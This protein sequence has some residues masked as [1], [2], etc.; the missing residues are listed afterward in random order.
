MLASKLPRCCKS[1]IGESNKCMVFLH[2]LVGWD[3]DLRTAATRTA[4]E[5]EIGPWRVWRWWDPPWDNTSIVS[6]CNLVEGG[7]RE[8]WSPIK[9]MITTPLRTWLTPKWQSRRVL[10]ILASYNIVFHLAQIVARRVCRV[11]LHLEV[12]KNTDVILLNLVAGKFF[13]QIHTIL[14]THFGMGAPIHTSVWVRF[15]GAFA[16]SCCIDHDFSRGVVCHGVLL[17]D[18]ILQWLPAGSQWFNLRKVWLGKETCFF[19]QLTAMYLIVFV[20]WQKMYPL[21]MT[22]IAIKNGPLK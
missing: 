11:V 1:L 19:L 22:N 6:W 10:I 2:F 14:G 21:G 16:D 8:L 15:K 17:P 13:S 7:D 3:S 4:G 9:T 18:T 12:C 20:E 5:F